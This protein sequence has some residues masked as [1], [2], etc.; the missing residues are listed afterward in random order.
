MPVLNELE[1]I[2]KEGKDKIFIASS[3]EELESLRV[4]FLGKKGKITVILKSLGNLSSKEKPVVGKKTNEVRQFIEGELIKRKKKLES[5]VLERKLEE[6][7]IDITLPGRCFPVGKRHLITQIID[8]ITD[9]FIGLGYKVAEGPE[10]ETEYYNFDALNTP[11][12]HPARS[13]MDTLYTQKDGVLLRTHTSPVQV[14]V[15]EKTLPPV[16]IIAPGKAYRRDVPDPS[17]SPMFHQVEGLAVDKKITFGDLK[18]TL[19]VFAKKMFGTDRD[20]RLRPHFFPFTEPSVEVDVSCMM[21]GGKGCRVCSGVGWLEILGAGMVDPNVLSEV[22]YDPEE[23]SGFAFG[24]GVER[25]AMLKYGV[26]DI[27]LFYENDLRFLEQF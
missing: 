21:C 12:D 22:G 2:K 20:V 11:A 5:K 16:Y 15:M 24:M 17:H 19:E 1:K 4:S 14:R 8:E 25:I 10:V 27:R 3:L 6:E 9:I 7:V 23:V 13:L 26:N 18:G